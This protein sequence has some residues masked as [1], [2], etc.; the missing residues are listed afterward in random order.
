MRLPSDWQGDSA[1]A[2]FIPADVLAA[3]HR[4]GGEASEFKRIMAPN[5]Q[6]AAAFRAEDTGTFPQPEK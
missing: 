2:N 4:S 5:R 1:V 3:Q 6:I